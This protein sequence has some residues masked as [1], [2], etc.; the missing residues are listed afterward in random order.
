MWSGCW[1]PP[2]LWGRRTENVLISRPVDLALLRDDNGKIYLIT[3]GTSLDASTK[4]TTTQ[5]ACC[6]CTWDSCKYHGKCWC[7]PAAFDKRPKGWLCVITDYAVVSSLDRVLFHPGDRHLC[8]TKS[9]ACL[10]CVL[11]IVLHSQRSSPSFVLISPVTTFAM[12]R[13]SSM[14]ERSLIRVWSGQSLNWSWDFEIKK[15]HKENKCIIA[16]WNLI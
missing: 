10:V 1:L 12:L 14:P 5:T 4:V 16:E 7:L 13:A 3:F 15:L 6:R 8:S 9:L 11:H 2:A